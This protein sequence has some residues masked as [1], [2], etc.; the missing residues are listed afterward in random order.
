MHHECCYC[1]YGYC[2]AVAE[3]TIVSML[4]YS[5]YILGVPIACRTHSYVTCGMHAGLTAACM[6]T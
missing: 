5:Y 4:L 2:D 3:V 1:S 6:L